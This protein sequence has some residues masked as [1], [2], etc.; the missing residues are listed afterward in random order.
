MSDEVTMSA[1]FMYA[2]MTLFLASFVALVW[3]SRKVGRGL[4][5]LGFA[6]AAGAFAVRWVESGH[7]PLQSLSDVFLALGVAMFPLS[8][9]WTRVLAARGEALDPLIGFVVLF[10]AALVFKSQPQELPPALQSP[11]FVPHVAAYV[12]AYVVLMKASILAAAGLLRSRAAGSRDAADAATY[13]LVRLG[14]PLLT[15]GLILGAWWGKL[16]WGD[17]WNWDPKE[18]WSLATWLFYLAYLHLH[19]APAGALRRLKPLVAIA[20]GAGILAT[21]VWVNLAGRIFEG[22]HSYA[23]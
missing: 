2:A 10:P 1:W 9:F 19:A 15:A 23:S 18:L 20:G 5:A 14:F 11:L 22:L 3:E 12:V 21:L 4:F 16:A 17:Y 6:A 8:L 13:R 7:A